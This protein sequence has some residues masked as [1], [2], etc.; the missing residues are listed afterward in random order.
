MLQI[1]LVGLPNV[2]K[3]TLFNVLSNLNI[4]AEDY[5]FCTIDPNEAVVEYKDPLLLSLAEA[6]ETQKILFP[7][8]KFIDIAGLVKG[9]HKGEGLG[10][11][12]LAHIREVDIILFVL[13]AFDDTN[14]THVLGRVN[15][16]EDLQIIYTELL[17]KDLESVQN[18]LDEI[19]KA[20]H[21]HS[22][23]EF[24][25]I[26]DILNGLKTYLQQEK[27]ALLFI[28]DY[29]LKHYQQ[30]LNLYKLTNR[31]TI[32]EIAPQLEIVLDLFLLTSKI[33]MF[34]LNISYLDT[35]KKEYLDRIN[36]YKTQIID[37]VK[38][39]LLPETL[40]SENHIVTLDPKTLQEIYQ[41]D[42]ASQ[43]EF[44]KE[45]TYF[46]T[47]QII[48]KNIIK[49]L[50]LKHVFVGSEKDVREFLLYHDATAKEAASQIHTDLAKNFIKAKIY[51]VEDVIANKG[52]QNVEYTLVGPDY[53]VED[54]DYIVV[55]AG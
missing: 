34:W 23:E 27:S 32:L 3:S 46:E 20:K 22:K 47:E 8:F 10:N 49:I 12:F 13:R 14:I 5:P 45:F 50:N 54:G 38:N 17:L 44:I 9:A 55:M 6:F 39:K 33:P 29:I 35:A 36:T 43:K 2:G 24:E 25:Q 15:P 51:K 19:K 4:P 53:V 26:T 31:Q 52:T 40:L 18:K 21:R 7:L 16:A 41:L 1:G 28:Y 42:K 37:Y 11:Q 30:K 48:M